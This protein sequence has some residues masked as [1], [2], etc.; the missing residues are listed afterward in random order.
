[1]MP[2]RRPN[3]WSKNVV[4]AM[5]SAAGFFAAGYFPTLILGNP[6]VSMGIAT[7]LMIPFGIGA[8]SVR[9]GALR[10]LVFGTVA[11]L[12]IVGA[13]A[14]LLQVWMA[15]DRGPAVETQPATGVSSGPASRP[16]SGPASTASDTQPAT[17]PARAPGITAIYAN[18]LVGT[19]GMCT[20][21]GALFAY[22]GRRRRERIEEQWR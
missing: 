14:M 22:L 19:I 17:Q 8:A 20:A 9:R 3:P 16:A 6:V 7:G 1:V 11:G 10:G 4:R 12:A 15:P 21:V 2:R 13:L 18:C 5:W